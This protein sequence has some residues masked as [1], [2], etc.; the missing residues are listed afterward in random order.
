MIQI[1]E[2]TGMEEPESLEEQAAQEEAVYP[3]T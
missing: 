1:S 2:R 3:L